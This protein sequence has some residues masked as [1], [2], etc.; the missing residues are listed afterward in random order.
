MAKPPKLDAVKLAK[1][2]V[3]QLSRQ[4]FGYIRHAIPGPRATFSFRDVQT[5]LVEGAIANEDGERYEDAWF[6][7][8]DRNLIRFVEGRSYLDHYTLSERGRASTYHDGVIDEPDPTV[9]ALEMSIGCAL[10]PTAKQYLRE[11]IATF[12]D[13][14]LLASQFC[15]GAV[16]ER[17]VFMLRD[18]IDGKA[19]SVAKI[20]KVNKVGEIIDALTTGF[21]ELRK[22]RADLPEIADLLGCIEHFAHAYRRSRN[23][24]GHPSEVREVNED[25]LALMLTAM[26]RRYVPTAYRVFS[27]QL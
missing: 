17:I 12:R 25:E 21:E 8:V 22:V 27:L 7:L 2:S 11:A 1:T 4:I 16:S 13:R 14:H 9:A 6:R 10:D 24:V 15:V 26:Q 3:D 20:T 18:W 5:R 19:A 23:E